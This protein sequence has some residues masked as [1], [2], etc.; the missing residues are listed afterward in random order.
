MRK[1]TQTFNTEETVKNI[2]NLLELNLEEIPH[3]DTINDVFET[4]NIEELRKIQKYMVTR[5]IRKK[6]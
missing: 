5:L 2:A 4:I 3:Y 6:M 1:V